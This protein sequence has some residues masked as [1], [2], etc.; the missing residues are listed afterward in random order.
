MTTTQYLPRQLRGRLTK[1]APEKIRTL[2]KKDRQ[3]L[4]ELNPKQ[5]LTS[6]FLKATYAWVVSRR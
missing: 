5:S 4:P 6:E 2:S 1:P 3:V